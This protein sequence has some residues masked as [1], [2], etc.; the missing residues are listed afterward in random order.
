MKKYS[1]T[2]NV[3]KF[4]YF[5]WCSANLS[6]SKCKEEKLTFQFLQFGIVMASVAMRSFQEEVVTPS[7]YLGYLG[8]LG[9]WLTAPK[10]WE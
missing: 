10:S 3:L 7:V 1:M 2:F 4:S 5:R 9:K 6:P 8:N